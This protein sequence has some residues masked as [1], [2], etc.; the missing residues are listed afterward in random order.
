MKYFG[1]VN[2]AGKLHIIHR[3][4]FD[5]ELLKQFAGKPVEIQV[6][7]KAKIRSLSQNAYYW[8]V[9]VALIQADLQEKYGEKTIT[10]QQVHELMKRECNK[11]EL[12]HEDDGIVIVIGLET[13]R[14]T[15]SEFMD[16]IESVREW[17]SMM[18]D[19]DIPEPDSQAMMSFDEDGMIDKK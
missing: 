18:L 9:V 15:T 13:K 1:T 7:K 5:A 12:F 19:L 8:G 14:L 4:Q 17:A 6:H 16:F 10:K 2:E 11:K 3:D